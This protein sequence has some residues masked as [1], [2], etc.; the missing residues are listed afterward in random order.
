MLA[1]PV[2]CFL[3]GAVAGLVSVGFHFVG[4]R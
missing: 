4:G 1:I 3:V 2:L